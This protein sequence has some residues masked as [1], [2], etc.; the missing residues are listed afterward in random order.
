MMLG[1]AGLLISGAG[2]RRVLGWT[3]LVLGVALF[4]PYADFVAL[5]V[6]LVWF[7]VAGSRA[8]PG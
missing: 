5:M 6:M 3:A 4:I 1:A 8:A 2:A 7:I